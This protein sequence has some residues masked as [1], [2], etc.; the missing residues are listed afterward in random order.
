MKLQVMPLLRV[1]RELYDIPLGR[2]R[3]ERYLD[4]MIG[5]SGD[6]VLPLGVMN[7]M[8][9]A[10][11]AAALDA[12]IALGAEEVAAAAV[13][14][15]GGRLS[16]L[17]GRLEV[18]LVVADDVEGGWTDRYLTET[19]HRFDNMGDVKR[20]WSVVLCWTSEAWSADR[21][22][23]EVLASIYRSLYIRRHGLPKTLRRMMTQEGLAAA[24]AG[25][26]Q[27]TLDAEELAYTREVIRPHVDS[28]HFPS[29]FACLY[30]DEA[31]RSVGYPALGLSARAGYA[32]AIEDA[33]RGEVAPEAALLG[34][35]GDA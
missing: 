10:H 35:P 32:V 17:D 29:V 9:K 1:Q 34:P 8:G 11:V 19:S 2:A 25:M 15:A 24:F 14:D 12:L 16:G 20:G 31:A 23:E 21:V 22:R 4:V 13:A 28:T 7:P 26:R 30:G 18:G 27:P 33:G 6:I 3:F 5:G